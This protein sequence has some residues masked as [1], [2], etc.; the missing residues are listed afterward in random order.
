MTFNTS[1]AAIRARVFSWA[2]AVTVLIIAFGLARLMFHRFPLIALLALTGF[3]YCSMFYVAGRLI[4]QVW[5]YVSKVTARSPLGIGER[6][7]ASSGRSLKG[8]G[9]AV[10]LRKPSRRS[11]MSQLRQAHAFGRRD[12]EASHG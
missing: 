8:Q 11:R 12:S 3:K 7:E 4:E 2:C 9:T 5:C 6:P 10:Q 1:A